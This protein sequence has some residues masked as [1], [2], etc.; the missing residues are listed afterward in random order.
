[1]VSKKTVLLL[2]SL[3]LIS[4]VGL[5]Q[6]YYKKEIDSIK[7]QLLL[8]K[9]LDT[10]RVRNYYW[11]GKLFY[12]ESIPDSALVY[13]N[14]SIQLA[15]KLKDTSWLSSS[16]IQEGWI[17]LANNKP[18]EAI[19]FG[20]KAYEMSKSN[21]ED[22]YF[23]FNSFNASN[24]L[25]QTYLEKNSYSNSLKHALKAKELYETYSGAISL[26]VHVGVLNTMGY[27]YTETENYIEA[28]KIINKT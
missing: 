4:F 15:K 2:S 26:E 16:Y 21:V 1:M 20:N 13:T 27:I 3:L 22:S 14:K 23:I 8:N 12:L 11:I 18:S 7:T 24:L 6:Q 19:I 10:N 9:E 5:S 28:L 17:H 25:L